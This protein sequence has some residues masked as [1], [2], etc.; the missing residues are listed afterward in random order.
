MRCAV[1]GHRWKATLLPGR[2]RCARC[3]KLV[4]R[5]KKVLS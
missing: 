3:A 1:F 2:V 5:V 4:D